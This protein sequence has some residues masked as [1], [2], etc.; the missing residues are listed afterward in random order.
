MHLINQTL[1]D[2][3]Y[4]M[5]NEQTELL[6]P[7]GNFSKM[8]MAFHYGADAVYLAGKSY[9]LRAFAGNFDND[10]L[11]N[12]VEY[13]HN[14]GKKIY[15]TL[16]ILAHEHDF[17][18]LDKYVLFLCDIKV[19]AVIVSD[20]GLIQFIKQYADNLPIHVSTQANVLNSY[21][22][23][24]LAEMGV[25]RIILAREVSIDEIREI[26]KNIPQNIEL[27]CFV[28]GAMCISYSGRCLLSNYLADRDAN[29]GMCVQACRWKYYISQQKDDGLYEIEQ[30]ERG[31][32]ILN[33]KDLN[34][35]SHLKELK[36]AGIVSMKIEGRMKSEYYTANVVNAYR[37]AIDNMENMDDKTLAVLQNELSKS[38]HREYTTGFYFKNE[39]KENL[40]SSMPVQTHEFMAIVLS[41]SKDGK[42]L[43][44]QRNRFKLGDELEILSVCENF[45][46]TFKVE[47]MTDENGEIITDASIVQQKL[48]LYTDLNLCKSDILRKSCNN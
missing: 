45:N 29:K 31:T 21:A 26:K 17:E 28:H 37:R 46:K 48:W 22:I 6:A 25:K 27:E 39:N 41:S 38:S 7:A 3:I 2:K 16:N 10:E 36:D 34:M 33:S 47:K 19:D 4:N 23:R 40:K 32:F 15:V 9:G 20:L 18:G 1:C 35:L 24:F 8:K 13:A 44:E 43:I 42:A 5:K 11:K 30:D 14:I 12:A